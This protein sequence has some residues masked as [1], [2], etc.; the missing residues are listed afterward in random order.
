MILAAMLSMKS[1]MFSQ[2]WTEFD[3]MLFLQDDKLHVH[4]RSS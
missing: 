3:K 2:F 1:I 4:V